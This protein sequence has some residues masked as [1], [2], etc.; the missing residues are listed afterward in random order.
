MNTQTPANGAGQANLDGA[1]PMSYRQES[2]NMT[3]GLGRP[4]TYLPEIQD[5]AEQDGRQS[6]LYYA[7]SQE[8][9]N[10]TAGPRQRYAPLSQMQGNVDGGQPM[11][12]HSSSQES[13]MTAGPNNR[14]TH[15]RQDSI[16]VAAAALS[17]GHEQ[18][19]Y[20]PPPATGHYLGRA[21]V[22]D[23]RLDR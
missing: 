12:Y 15:L 9:H 20:Y 18:G 6:M 23:S 16:G 7:A 8:S 5:G 10:M 13:H 19:Y 3:A 1:Q 4:Y 14:Y 21:E 2:H 17:P 11:L 22:Q